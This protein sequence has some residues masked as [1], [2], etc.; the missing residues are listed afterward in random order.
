MSQIA[1]LLSELNMACYK[2][3]F[4]RELVDGEMLKDLD[5]E[6]LESLGVDNFHIKKLMM[7]IDGWRPNF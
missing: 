5:E 1:E 6:S 7:F 4:Q 2:E 3:V